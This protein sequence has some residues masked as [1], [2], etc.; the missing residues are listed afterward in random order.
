MLVFTEIVAVNFFS[1]G[2]LS[3]RSI[4]PFFSAAFLSMDT[5]HV[6]PKHVSVRV[7]SLNF[8]GAGR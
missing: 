1:C 8:N 3:F 2:N 4:L 6:V 5:C 7:N